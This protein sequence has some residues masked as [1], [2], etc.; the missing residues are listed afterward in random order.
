[1]RLKELTKHIFEGRIKS[2]PESYAR[3]IIEDTE[4]FEVSFR[5][6][7]HEQ[8]ILNG[9]IECG[10]EVEMIWT[11]K[12]PNY[13]A[14]TKPTVTELRKA[15]RSNK[16]DEFYAKYPNSFTKDSIIIINNNLKEEYESWINSTYYW[17]IQKPNM[18]SVV[19][20]DKYNE[21]INKFIDDEFLLKGSEF[22]KR[23]N[24]RFNQNATDREKTKPIDYHKWGKIF[25]R[26]EGWYRENIFISYVEKHPELFPGVQ[27]KLDRE[28]KKLT[29]SKFLKDEDNYDNFLLFLDDSN[30]VPDLVSDDQEDS[31]AAIDNLMVHMLNDWVTPSSSV[32]K[33]SRRGGLDGLDNKKWH[34]HED[35]SVGLDADLDKNDIPVEISSPVFPTPNIML[36][37]LASLFTYMRDNKVETDETTGLHVTMSYRGPTKPLNKVKIV[38]LLNDRYWLEKFNREKNE[39]TSSQISRILPNID[40]NKAIKLTDKQL[41]KIE[42]VIVPTIST[43]KY[44]A[45]HF[46]RLENIDKNK[47]VEF[48]ILGNKGY[49]QQYDEVKKAVTQYAGVMEAGYNPDAFKEEYDEEL[50]K[51]LNLIKQGNQD[52]LEL[53]KLINKLIQSTGNAPSEVKRNLRKFIAGGEDAPGRYSFLLYFVDWLYDIATKNKIK[54]DANEQKILVSGLKQKEAYDW[55]NRQLHT[56]SRNSTIFKKIQTVLFGQST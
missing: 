4:L 24:S 51:I 37:E 27:E 33:V 6:Q 1:M 2:T 46:K 30:V 53:E 36:T 15:F 18:L 25:L 10:F 23:I 41:K 26:N 14:K 21:G 54:L 28:K 29:F 13:A 40:V 44:N 19:D 52:S 49:E 8:E 11:K 43:D 16:L 50:R 12:I 20:N 5:D 17:D 32:K 34:F 55:V 35:S 7:E 3:P 31:E 47:L 42:Q 39:Y 45:I 56:L 38:L 9:P 22:K 48:R